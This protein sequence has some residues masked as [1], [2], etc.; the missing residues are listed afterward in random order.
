MKGVLIFVALLSFA[1]STTADA[2]YRQ[3]DLTI[4]GMD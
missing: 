3:V 4:Y 1:L 2:E